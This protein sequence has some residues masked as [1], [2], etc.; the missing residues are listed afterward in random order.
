M[1]LW[2]CYFQGLCLLHKYLKVD[3]VN[4]SPN[5]ST[6]HERFQSSEEEPNCIT[7]PSEV[8]FFTILFYESWQLSTGNCTLDN[9]CYYV[10]MKSESSRKMFLFQQRNWLK[11]Q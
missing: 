10:T 8:E 2:I 6:D 11:K 5:S 3:L 1:I 4:R 9:I 7:N